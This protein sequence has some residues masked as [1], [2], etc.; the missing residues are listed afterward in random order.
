MCNYGWVLYFPRIIMYHRHPGRSV[1]VTALAASTSTCPGVILRDSL[2]KHKP[3][4]SRKRRSIRILQGRTA[5]RSQIRFPS[6]YRSQG[7]RNPRRFTDFAVRVA[8]PLTVSCQPVYS[9]PKGRAPQPFTKSGDLD[10]RLRTSYQ[11]YK[12][13]P[14]KSTV[15]FTGL[16]TETGK[17]PGRRKT[18][19]QSNLK[20]EA[21]SFAE[22]CSKWK[23]FGP[24]D[25]KA[26]VSLLLMRFLP[27][28]QSRCQ[29]E[30]PQIRNL[31][32]FSRV[33]KF[34][35]TST[36]RGR[37]LK[38]GVLGYLSGLSLES[39]D[40]VREV[41][42]DEVLRLSRKWEKGAGGRRD[43]V[44]LTR[45]T[46]VHDSS[47]PNTL[48]VVAGGHGRTSSRKR[49]P[50][51]CDCCGP[52]C[53]PPAKAPALEKPGRRGRRK[54]VTEAGSVTRTT[55]PPI[56]DSALVNGATESEGNSR[57]GAEMEV[58]PPV[59]EV[60]SSVTLSSLMVAAVTSMVT[61]VT[62]SVADTIPPVTEVM[63]SEETSET[64]AVV[65]EGSQLGVPILESPELEVPIVESSQGEVPFVESHRLEVLPQSFPV[66]WP[67]VLL[68]HQYCR[69]QEAVSKSEEPRNKLLTMEV[70]DE[71]LTELIH[72]FL[73]HFYGKYGSFIPLCEADVLEHLNKKLNCDLA[74]RQS[75]VMSAVSK[76]RGGLA[77]APMNGFR[78]TY[79]K[80]T[81][82]LEDLS[83]LDDQN[84][85][86]DQVINMYGEL[87]V[88]AANHKVHFFNSFFHRQ[89][90]AKGYEGVKRWTKKVD[91]FS[92]TLLLIPIHLEIHW[93]LI[94]VDVPHR[95]IHFYDSQGIMFKYAVE[96][97]LKYILAE[98]KE[99]QR[100]VYQKGWKMTV[101]KSI[102]QQ[103]NDSDCG[104]FVLEYCK[105]L[106]LKQPLHFTQEDMPKVRMRI[107]KELCDCKL[108]C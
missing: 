56:N 84:W 54:K 7:H 103:K 16:S 41:N 4:H 37:R 97:I 88:E 86:N 70:N 5:L 14:Q 64:E 21:S 48:A 99:K 60:M 92:K 52:N 15:K 45:E 47:I 43:G 83:T 46:M 13:L 100:T 93:S 81:L 32:K 3:P 12:F 76:Y 69:T 29:V 80:H 87:I 61:E 102:P 19:Y 105:R 17:L 63:L 40:L 58:E 27:N 67:D 50:K 35:R 20:K 38:A 96:N 57:H 108:K 72:E 82:T 104:V 11:S 22:K 30:K 77:S 2:C 98:A 94:T 26:V 95:T 44:E 59:P 34:S 62:S 33:K 25:N 28:I 18:S 75:F 49:T 68:D 39:E 66:Q 85:V 78:V 74:S 73:E 55:P 42:G 89:L 36:L 1:N 106:A 23:V 71:D 31:R 91:L 9:N 65:E 79:N 10:W 51:A 24:C 107:Y 6:E 101:N 8:R 53:R 90:V